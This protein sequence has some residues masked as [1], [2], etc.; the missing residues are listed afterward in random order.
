MKKKSIKKLL[1]YS[2]S[3]FFFLIIVLAV[4]IYIVYRPK[5]PSEYTRVLAR[6][7]IKQ[8]I[9]VED[10]TEITTWLYQQK[11]VDHV[12]VNPH[13]NIVVFTFFPIKASANQIVNN[14]KAR[15]TLKLTGSC[16]LLKI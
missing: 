13:T 6:I 3:L 5:A 14:F 16:L 11:A 7:D 4:H 15:F 9:T 10:S 1:I 8:Q 12:L 2:F